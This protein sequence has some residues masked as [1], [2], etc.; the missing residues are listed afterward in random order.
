M[1]IKIKDLETFA[2]IGIHDHERYK[3]QRLILNVTLEYD[4]SL[5]A[6]TDEIEHAIDYEKLAHMLIK[7]IETHAYYLLEALSDHLIKIIMKDQRIQSVELEID[8]P[9][10]LKKASSVSIRER[11]NRE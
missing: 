6:Q 9:D 8:K 4:A 1:I 10:A 5:A 3:K 2:L 7:E 11:R